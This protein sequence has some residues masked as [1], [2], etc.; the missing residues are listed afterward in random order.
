MHNLTTSHFVA[1]SGQRTCHLQHVIGQILP[2]ESR[3]SNAANVSISSLAAW[4]IGDRFGHS[5]RPSLFISSNDTPVKGA[6]WSESGMR[7]RLSFSLTHTYTNKLAYKNR[8]LLTLTLSLRGQRLPLGRGARHV[9]LTGSNSPAKVLTR[10]CMRALCSCTQ[11]HGIAMATT[12]SRQPYQ[13]QNSTS[14]LLR[15]QK[16]PSWLT[17][18]W[19]RY[20]TLLPSI[21]SMQRTQTKWW[22]RRQA[23]NTFSRLSC[24]T[25]YVSFSRFWT[26][27]I[28]S[29]SGTVPLSQLYRSTS[30]GSTG[31]MERRWSSF[32]LCPLPTRRGEDWDGEATPRLRQRRSAHMN[33]TTRRRFCFFFLIRSSL[34]ISRDLHFLS[35]SRELG[36][37]GGWV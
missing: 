5:S 33:R 2:R 31:A 18:R 1:P 36:L 16:K 27:L 12:H 35:Q 8:P 20:L 4:G 37:L 9:H 34:A 32:E 28:A 29:G 17:H 14:N 11:C 13:T 7:V 19:Y 23:H 25:F 15:S 10:H 24:P 21:E 30:Y 26:H 3:R 6:L 22:R